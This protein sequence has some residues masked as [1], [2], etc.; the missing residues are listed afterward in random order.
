MTFL[1]V[2][3][4]NYNIIVLELIFMLAASVLPERF[5]LWNLQKRVDRQEWPLNLVLCFRSSPSVKHSLCSW[6]VTDLDLS[7]ILHS[8]FP[9]AFIKQECHCTSV[10]TFQFLLCY[11]YTY[12]DQCY[13]TQDLGTR[14][15]LP[16]FCPAHPPGVYI[17]DCKT[18]ADIG[19]FLRP[20]D[21]LKLF[22]SPCLIQW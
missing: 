16:P 20:V 3:I 19:K 21:F 11:T 9:S 12:R 8:Q 15:P 22:F 14:N 18:R 6:Q 5:H 4:K 1:R 7:A 17:E 2:L 13:K 10:F